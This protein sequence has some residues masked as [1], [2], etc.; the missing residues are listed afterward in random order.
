MSEEIIQGTPEWHALRIG[1][2]TAS[3]V[4]DV[5]AKTK[6]GWGASRANYAAQLVA[7]RLTGEVA[8]SY[9]NAA[10]TWGIEKEPDARAAYEF[11][12]DAEVIEVGFIEHPS[13]AMTGASPDGFIGPNGLVEIKAPNTATHIETLLGQVVPSKYILQMQWQMA[14]SGR[15][16][17]DFVSYDPRLPESMRLFVKRV[18]RDNIK[19]SEISTEIVQFLVEVDETVRRLNALYGAKAAA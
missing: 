5:M 12:T 10:M 15:Q 11:R 2:V 19:I 6:T 9:T 7:E 13:I 4:A 8:E 18:M 17:C 1:K 3:R 16:W 14:C